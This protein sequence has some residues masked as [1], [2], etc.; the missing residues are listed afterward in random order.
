VILGFPFLCPF[1]KIFSDA[2]GDNSWNAS[3][4]MAN[5]ELSNVPIDPP[6]PL[7]RWAKIPILDFEQ[8]GKLIH[9]TNYYKRRH[10]CDD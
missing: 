6:A 3:R 7:S 10:T 8:T 9:E 4:Q 5:V 1:E 2:D